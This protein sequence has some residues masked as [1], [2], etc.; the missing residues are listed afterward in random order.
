MI[1]EVFVG[2]VLIVLVSPLLFIITFGLCFLIE[3]LREEYF[4]G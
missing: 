4:Y 1:N 2:S 3:I